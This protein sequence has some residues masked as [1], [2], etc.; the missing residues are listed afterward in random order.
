MSDVNSDELDRLQA[1]CDAATPGPW[2]ECRAD[3]G[4]C[5]CG[6]VYSLPCDAHIATAEGIHNEEKSVPTEV[7]QKNATFIAESRTALPSLIAAYRAAMAE[8]ERLRDAIDGARDWW[9]VSVPL[10]SAA[11]HAGKLA[12]A[13]MS[14]HW[15]ERK[16]VELAKECQ[17]TATRMKII[18]ANTTTRDHP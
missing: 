1:M 4:G 18:P 8:N 15:D 14:I 3:D 13:N 6:M 7:Q 16:A 11:E 12:G 17:G 10:K 9:C 5:I 2:R